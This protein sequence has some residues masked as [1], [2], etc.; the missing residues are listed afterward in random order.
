MRFQ[1]LVVA[2]GLVVGSTPCLVA[3]GPSRTWTVTYD[4]DVT[5]DGDSVIVKK[6][7]T[8]RLVL[9]QRGDSI[10]GRFSVPGGPEP[11]ERAL[12]GTYDGKVLKLTTGS[13]RRTIRINGEPTEMMTRTD[14]M[15]AVN[16][17]SMRG[18]MFIQVG[19][20][21]APPRRWEAIPAQP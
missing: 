9:E 10:F 15:G 12:S 20:R 14:W 1:P 3:Q 2:L 4:S 5:L 19:D 16:G 11:G 13:A 18:T 8:G 17:G 7:S 6:R 21:P